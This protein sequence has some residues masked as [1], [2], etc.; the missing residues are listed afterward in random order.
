MLLRT[1]APT[2]AAPA[3]AD[4]DLMADAENADI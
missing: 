3:M 1:N 4:R 2:P